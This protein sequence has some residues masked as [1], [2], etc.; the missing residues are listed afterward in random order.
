M[1][2]KILELKGVSLLNKKHQQAIK[3]GSYGC[4]N[5]ARKCI[6]DNDCC[7]GSCGEE[8]IINGRPILLSICAIV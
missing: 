5:M 7:S 4:Q 6:A 2:H 1:I 8:K 3:A